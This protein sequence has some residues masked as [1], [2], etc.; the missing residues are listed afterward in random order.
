MAAG[1][2]CAATDVQAFLSLAAGQDDALLGVLC[3]RAS[4]FVQNML[5]RKLLTASYTG[6]FSGRGNNRI[7]LPN[8]PITAVASVTVDGVAIPAAT[9]ALDAGFLFD[10]NLVY[11]RGYCF[12]RGVQNVVIVYTAGFA[13]VPADVQQACVE[14]VAAKYKRRTELHVSGKTLN[15]ETINFSQADVPASAKAALN[16]YK[17]VGLTA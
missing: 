2:L 3:T 6:T 16:S 15:G 12:S 7:G 14:I 10:E 8:Y 13:E 1:D 9:G 17:R 5:N 4:A 11:L